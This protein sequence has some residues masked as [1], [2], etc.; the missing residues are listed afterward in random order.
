MASVVRNSGMAKLG[1]FGLSLSC[2]CGK[3]V[4]RNKE[5]LK[6]SSLICQVVRTEDC[7]SL[8]LE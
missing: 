3:I 1:N 7:N 6:A 2:R 8:G 5:L 4:A